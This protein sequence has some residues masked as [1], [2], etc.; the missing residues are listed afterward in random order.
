MK[1]FMLVLLACLALMA[2]AIVNA[3]TQSLTAADS[4]YLES[5][6]G[7]SFDQQVAKTWTDIC[8]L[9]RERF[10][11]SNMVKPGD[12]IALPLRRS[13][14]AMMAPQ[15]ASHMWRASVVFV[16]EVVGKYA[17]ERMQHILL[18]PRPD[19]TN[20]GSVAQKEYK[21]GRGIINMFLYI[22]LIL[23]GIGLLGLLAR[24]LQNASRR[25]AFVKNPPPT[26]AP[27]SQVR[28]LAER[29]LQQ[30]YGR[31]FQIIGDIERGVA[32]G[33]QTMFN[34]DGSSEVVN[35]YNEPAFRARIRFNN[36]T[37]KLVV[38]RWSCFNPC[39]NHVNSAYKGTFTPGGGQ[40]EVIENVSEKEVR[41]MRENIRRI[42]RE[43]KI[44]APPVFSRPGSPAPVKPPT[45]KTDN[46]M[47]LTK[48]QISLEKG[49]NLEG[50]DIPI[51]VAELKA[52]VAQLKEVKEEKK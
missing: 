40:P 11:D 47:H 2:P 6:L 14:F 23:L 25:R 3:Q 16:E 42:A 15:G 45:T 51:T 21:P 52:L 41:D 9:N 49:I 18:A 33:R 38:C 24:H 36:G 34:S 5:F 35:F 48:V 8:A 31:D 26:N 46:K 22:F 32:N 30:T 20:M 43:E 10:P 19:S 13:Y 12:I 4:A 39:V 28:P 44:V 7:K 37:E 27:D 50:P 1:R 17:D 29:A